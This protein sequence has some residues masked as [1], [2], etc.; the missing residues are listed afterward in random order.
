MNES[1]ELPI[2]FSVDLTNGSYK[3]PGRLLVRSTHSRVGWTV[4]FGVNG[5]SWPA[6]TIKQ[7]NQG[8]AMV[9]GGT[10]WKRIPW[11]GQGV[12]PRGGPNVTLAV[13]SKGVATYDEIR[14]AD[15]Y[16]VWAVSPDGDER[17]LA[18]WTDNDIYDTRRDS[19]YGTPKKT[20]RSVI[21]GK[22]MVVPPGYET[23][24]EEPVKPDDDEIR[25]P[26]AFKPWMSYPETLDIGESW[27]KIRQDRIDFGWA[28]NTDILRLPRYEEG[29]RF[30]RV[31][32]VYD[33]EVNAWV[34]GHGE[35]T[36]IQ[37]GVDESLG[38][39]LERWS[40][41]NTLGETVRAKSRDSAVQN[42]SYQ[43]KEPIGFMVVT[44]DD[45]PDPQRTPVQW[46]GFEEEPPPD[47]DYKDGYNAALDDGIEALEALR[48]P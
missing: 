12:E 18:W 8:T 4:Y 22:G 23:K 37:G 26:T 45:N 28:D 41:H 19:G 30:G 44:H 43:P 6:G 39:T 35:H 29:D 36:R 38:T 31:V 7:G 5:K 32:L 3:N 16:A 48:K 20:R 47:D 13:A 21:K 33:Y 24:P 10:A 11:N 46:F 2:D 1:L 15:K 40:E 42:S 14:A 17:S 27:I 9:F 34:A 25:V